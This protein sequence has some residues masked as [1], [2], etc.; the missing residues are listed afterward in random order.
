LVFE[1]KL[2]KYEPFKLVCHA[3][4][5]GIPLVILDAE[6]DVAVPLL[7]VMLVVVIA[8]DDTVPSTFTDP[9]TSIPLWDTS[10][11]PVITADPLNGKALPA[12]EFKAKL[13]VNANEADVGINVI[14]V[15]A[16]AVVANE[17]DM[18]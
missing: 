7:A 18:A 10:N 2:L 12:P 6:I 15:A 9:V 13:A 3:F 16:D 8:V 11:D 5:V 17:D 4:D 1:V 14:D